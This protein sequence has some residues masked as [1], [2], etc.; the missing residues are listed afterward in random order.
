MDYLINMKYSRNAFKQSSDCSS[1][2][3]GCIMRV[4]NFRTPS[5]MDNFYSRLV[6][7]P[8]GSTSITQT[9]DIYMLLNQ[10]RLDRSTLEAFS[11]LLDSISVNSSDM[12]SLRSKC[13]DSQLLQF[14]KSRYIQAPS[15]LLAWSKY[16]ESMYP[17]EPAPTPTSSAPVSQPEPTAGT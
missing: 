8:D 5:S 1:Y 13:S 4:S 17:A 12:V 9:T 14:C 3:T 16:L 11:Q 15:Q 2:S 7:N 6:S 10:K